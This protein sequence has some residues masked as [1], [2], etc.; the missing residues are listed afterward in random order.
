MTGDVSLTHDSHP[1]CRITFMGII[2]ANCGYPIDQKRNHQNLSAMQGSSNGVNSAAYDLNRQREQQR[3]RKN[4]VGKNR[5]KRQEQ[6]RRRDANNQSFGKKK[7]RRTTPQTK[8]FGV[9]RPA[10]TITADPSGFGGLTIWV[11]EKSCCASSSSAAWVY[12]VTAASG[13]H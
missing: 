4:N 10:W 6:K 9:S 5:K 2:A 3:G 12:A 7:R 11:D 13:S 1:F 8:V